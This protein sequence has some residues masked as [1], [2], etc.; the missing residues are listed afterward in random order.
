MSSAS[1]SDGVTQSRVL[2]VRVLRMC[3]AGYVVGGYALC[4]LMA[5]GWLSGSR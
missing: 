5:A 2:R 4:P 1:F 3:A